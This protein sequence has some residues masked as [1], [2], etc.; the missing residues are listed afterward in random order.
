MYLSQP[1]TNELLPDRHAQVFFPP[2]EVWIREFTWKTAAR[3]GFL[4][5]PAAAHLGTH[6]DPWLRDVEPYGFVLRG[7]S[8][9]SFPFLAV[10]LLPKI[11]VVALAHA[12][13]TPR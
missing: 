5:A 12:P 4:L 13:S 8:I 9:Q 2:A 7:M 6:I 3:F 10:H 1:T 11:V